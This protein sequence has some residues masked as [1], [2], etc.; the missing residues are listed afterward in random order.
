MSKSIC[1]I[2]TTFNQI[3]LL[4]DRLATIL[5]DS[6]HRGNRNENR[7]NRSDGRSKDIILFLDVNNRN[8]LYRIIGKMAYHW[9]QIDANNFHNK[10]TPHVIH[11]A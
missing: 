3:V 4:L 2:S 6:Y 7:I 9:Y 10:Y 11:K 8:I 1:S 5:M